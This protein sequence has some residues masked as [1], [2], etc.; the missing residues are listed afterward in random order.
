VQIPSQNYLADVDDGIYA[1]SYLRAWLLEGAFR[2]ILQ[3][4]YSM[5]WFCNPKAIDFLRQLWSHGQNFNADQLLLKNGGGKLD[6]DPLKH[7]IERALG[8]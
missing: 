6:A 8:R 7:H 3:D 1:A 2:M 5:E 4:R